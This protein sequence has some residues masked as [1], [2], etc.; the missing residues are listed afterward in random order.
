MSFEGLLGHVATIQQLVAETDPFGQAEKEWREHLT[1]VRCR[2]TAAS[3]RER[4]T[5][6]TRDELEVTHKMF[7]ESSLDITEAMRVSEVRDA[8]GTVLGTDFD[9]VAVQRPSGG[10]GEVHH[11]EVLLRGLRD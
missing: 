11:M 8:S 7:V 9:V 2:L 10:L 6:G 5:L 4:S 3:G 1:G